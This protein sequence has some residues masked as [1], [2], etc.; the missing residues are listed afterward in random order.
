[1]SG[2]RLAALSVFGADCDLLTFVIVR[3][4]GLIE[5]KNM[6]AIP[7]GRVHRYAELYSRKC[8]QK[9]PKISR[10]QVPGFA[11]AILYLLKSF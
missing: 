5:K 11:P 7:N 1:M 9:E 10:E 6:V 4:M 8:C 3:F 2:G